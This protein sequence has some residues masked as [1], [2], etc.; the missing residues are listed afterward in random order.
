MPYMR[1]FCGIAYFEVLPKCYVITC[2]VIMLPGISFRC[3][4][5]IYIV[6]S[7]FLSFFSPMLFVICYYYIS[8]RG[9]AGLEGQLSRTRRDQEEQARHTSRLQGKG[10]QGLRIHPRLRGKARRSPRDEG[11]LFRGEEARSP[12]SRRLERGKGRRETEVRILRCVAP[13][14][15][16]AD[17][18]VDVFACVCV[19]VNSVI[20]FRESGG[21]ALA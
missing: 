11:K 19:C 5:Q 3:Y 7:F 1:L 4:H 21:A 12:S 18:Y 17:A 2:C 6:L 15:V 8:P 9:G 20:V 10:E 13:R 16:D 14:D